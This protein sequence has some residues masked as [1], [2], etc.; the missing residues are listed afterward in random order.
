M[1]QRQAVFAVVQSIVG[2]IS[3]K[4]ELNKA[5]LE[6]AKS[7]LFILFKS[8]E[9]DLR[10]MEQRDDAYLKKYIPG[11]INNWLRKDPELNGGV[12]YQTKN[13]GIRA[14][15]GDEMLKNL[16]LLL[17]TT[18]D[19]TA[20]QAITE[21]LQK[22]KDALAK[23]KLKPINAEFIPEHLRHLIKVA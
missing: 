13:P 20:K 7:D 2:E 12:K 18:N 17:Q 16:Q 22:R 15:S 9:V 8:G 4:V 21:E 23:A 10:N 3:G 5:Q 1:N 14:G 6:Q 11:L 19:P